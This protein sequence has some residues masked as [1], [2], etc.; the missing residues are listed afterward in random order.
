MLY[1]ATIAVGR[2]VLGSYI[3]GYTL[4][5]G[6]GRAPTGALIGVLTFMGSFAGLESGHAMQRLVA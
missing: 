3:L 1:C 4:D 2:V 6:A 5:R